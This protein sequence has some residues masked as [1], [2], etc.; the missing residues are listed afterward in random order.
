MR[1]SLLQLFAFTVIFCST[2]VYPPN[3]HAQNF[4]V[5]IV[6]DTANVF[7][8]QLSN[9]IRQIDTHF[10]NAKDSLV[11]TTGQKTWTCKENYKMDGAHSCAI[12]QRGFNTIYVAFFLSRDSKD[13]LESSY[14]NLCHQLEDCMGPNYVYKEKKATAADMLLGS[15]DYK[16]EMTPS[17][18]AVPDQADMLV[19]VEKDT[20]TGDYELILEIQK[21]RGYY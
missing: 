7:Y 6:R 1:Y 9:V 20:Q 8:R 18:D 5:P 13:A 12:Y 16:C 4:E 14:H 3:V 11:D 17:R 15:K 2:S 21:Y 19:S 10:D